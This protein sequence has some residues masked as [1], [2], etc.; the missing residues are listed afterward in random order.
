[1]DDERK[2]GRKGGREGGREGGIERYCCITCLMNHNEN[3]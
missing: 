1:M 3:A 2:E